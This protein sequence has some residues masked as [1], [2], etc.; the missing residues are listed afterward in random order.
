MRID[1]EVWNH[2]QLAL[3]GAGSYHA[4][5]QPVGQVASAIGK[6]RV[7]SASPGDTL[8]LAIEPSKTDGHISCY[9][10]ILITS[11]QAATK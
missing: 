6:G 2:V 7:R 4:A 8:R 3:D 11:G 5:V 10:N 1:Y 9:D